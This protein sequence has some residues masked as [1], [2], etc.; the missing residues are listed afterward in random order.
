MPTQY[1]LKTLCQMLN[2]DISHILQ[3]L[4][5]KAQEFPLAKELKEPSMYSFVYINSLGERVSCHIL[6]IIITQLCSYPDSM[7]LTQL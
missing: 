4:W 1:S 2:F 7:K 3:R 5:K 6:V